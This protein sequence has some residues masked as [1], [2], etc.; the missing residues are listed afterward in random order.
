MRFTQRCQRFNGLPH[1]DTR[2]P[3]VA[4]AGRVGLNLYRLVWR[5]L[6]GKPGSERIG[7]ARANTQHR[8]SPL[9]GLFDRRGARRSAV[10]AVKTALSFVKNALAH[11]HGGVCHRHLFH[12]RLKGR[13]QTMAEYQEVR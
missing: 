8:I 6:V 12:P 1:R 2:K 7:K 9:D 3:D 5:Q 11:Q 13:A 10:G 4:D